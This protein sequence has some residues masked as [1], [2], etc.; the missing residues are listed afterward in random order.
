[1]SRPV[2]SAATWFRESPPASQNG[3]VIGSIAEMSSLNS[4]ANSTTAQMPG[5]RSRAATGSANA[6]LLGPATRLGNASDPRASAAV[7]PA[8][9]RKAAATRPCGDLDEE[10]LETKLA[11]RYA[12]IRT[13]FATPSSRPEVVSMVYA[14]IAMSWVAESVT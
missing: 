11:P 9:A 1:M 6:G 3:L 14:S 4:R 8:P 7:I 13:E 2:V 5:R 12:A 10:A